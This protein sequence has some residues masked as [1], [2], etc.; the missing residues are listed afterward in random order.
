MLARAD[1]PDGA[2]YEA[3]DAGLQR[4]RGPC[5]LRVASCCGGCLS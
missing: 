5:A 3:R 2:G 4:P 1:L